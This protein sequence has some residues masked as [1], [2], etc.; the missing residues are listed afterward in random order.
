MLNHCKNSNRP[1]EKKIAPKKEEEIDDG[2]GNVT[3]AICSQTISKTLWSHHKQRFHNNLAW[4]IGDPP[5][6][7]PVCP[8]PILAHLKKMFQDLSDQSFVMYTLNNLYKKKK[9]LYCDKCGEMKKSVVGFLSHQSQCSKSSEQLE[10]V[11][12]TCELCGKKMLP[13]SMPTHMKFVHG[14]KPEKEEEEDTSRVSPVGSKR[15]AHKKYNF[16]LPLS[17]VTYYF[18][19]RALAILDSI[20]KK[21]SESQEFYT[22]NLDFIDQNVDL[23]VKELKDKTVVQCKFN[24]DFE[25]SEIDDLVKHHMECSE[26]PE[27]VKKMINFWVLFHNFLLGVCVC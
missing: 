21:G 8:N 12:A 26:K 2:S 11:K 16:I 15:G 5:L 9:P 17:I 18:N 27:E 1:Y 10:S 22:T 24:C 3:C 20:N 6:V 25:S 23:I 14:P 4:R 19:Y 7:R 13:V